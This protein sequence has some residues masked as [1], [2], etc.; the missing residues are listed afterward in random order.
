MLPFA[1]T[2]AEVEAAA[3]AA[4][5]ANRAYSKIADPTGGPYPCWRDVSDAQRASVVAGV[6]CVIEGATPREL[7]EKWLAYK[8]KE[9]WAFGPVKDEKSKQH[10]CMLPYLEL[11][12]AARVKD[13]LFQVTVRGMLLAFGR[14]RN[15]D[16]FAF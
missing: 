3:R 8:A 4:H 14:A 10:P 7:H 6:S 2:P 11:P 12:T 1:Y 9:G 16:L 13:E 15:P 5:E